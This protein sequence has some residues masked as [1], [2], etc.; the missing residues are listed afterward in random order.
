MAG[1]D[2]RRVVAKAAEEDDSGSNLS[3]LFS[4]DR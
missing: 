1:S 3:A 2:G 4:R